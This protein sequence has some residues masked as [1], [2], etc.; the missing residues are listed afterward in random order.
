MSKTDFI[1]ILVF[2]GIGLLIAGYLIFLLLAGFSVN[3]ASTSSPTSTLIQS[4][5]SQAEI[6][7]SLRSDPVWLLNRLT[8]KV[9]KICLALKVSCD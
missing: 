1:I 9:N 7:V 3:A 8:A 2:S 4:K 6:L 5:L